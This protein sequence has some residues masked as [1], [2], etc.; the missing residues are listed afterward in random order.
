LIFIKRVDVI[1]AD[2][3]SLDTVH[4]QPINYCITHT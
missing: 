1:A 4:I 3:S 2:N